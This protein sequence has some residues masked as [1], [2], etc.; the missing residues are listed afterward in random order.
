[1]TTTLILGG[2]RSGKSRHAESLL[3][4]EPAVTYIATGPRADSDDSDWAARVK[5]HQDRR[6]ETWTTVESS[7]VTHAI[8]AAR[9]PTLVDCIGNW[10]TALIDEA[11]AWEDRDKALTLVQERCT[12]LVALWINAPYDI[13]AVTNEVGMS[14]VP[15]TSSGRLFGDA[16]GRVNATLS[17]VSDRV[18]LV[19][20]GRVVDLSG[21]PVVPGA[22]A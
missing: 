22:L 12:E 11:E 7:D 18:H 14:V 16:L 6:P 13:V 2:T 8:L 20:A 10:V 21:L 3:I 19:V 17:S 1:M 5:H 15:Q 4:D 9:T